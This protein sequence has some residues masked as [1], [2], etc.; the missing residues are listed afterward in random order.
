MRLVDYI[1]EGSE[2][3]PYEMIQELYRSSFPFIKEFSGTGQFISMKNGMFWSGRPSTKVMDTRKI[4]KNRAPTDTGG[5]VH[6]YADD[7]FYKE[8]G[9]RYRSNAIF[10]TGATRMAASYGTN[11]YGIFPR[12]N[13]Y[14]YAW[15]PS[16][17]DLYDEV[18]MDDADGTHAGMDPDDYVDEYISGDEEHRQ[19]NIAIS[20]LRSIFDAQNDVSEFYTEP[21][22]ISYDNEGDLK[23]AKEQAQEDAE[24]DYDNTKQD[25]VD[26]GVVGKTKELLWDIANE[27]IEMS[28][29][30]VRDVIDGYKEG[31][32]HKAI[33][34]RHEIM[35]S[36]DSYNMV[37]YDNMPYV[38]HY[39][40]KMGSKQPTPERWKKAMSDF[41][42][43]K[44]PPL[45]GQKISRLSLLSKDDLLS[46]PDE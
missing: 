5:D 43:T 15:S 29:R 33:K 25:Y 26:G 44:T 46:M 11:V 8:F 30:V 12:G 21:D 45:P 42:N 1:V 14:S 23:V 13:N 10:V 27:E 19:R 39:I 17:K 3:N 22:P 24:F 7:Q 36:G 32:I 28:E 18:M 9:T 6:H 37:R 20:T 38:L 31:D 2:K 34:S 40:D 4:R 16:I 41:D 35:L